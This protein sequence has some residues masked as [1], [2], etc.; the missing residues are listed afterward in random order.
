LSALTAPTSPSI[1]LRTGNNFFFF[2]Q[3]TV[4]LHRSHFGREVASSSLSVDCSS[5]FGHFPG[6]SV[7][8]QPIEAQARQIGILFAEVNAIQARLAAL[9]ESPPHT[10]L[11][12]RPSHQGSSRHCCLQSVGCAN[13]YLT[14]SATPDADAVVADITKGSWTGGALDNLVF[15][16]DT[17]ASNSSGSSS[18]QAVDKA[19]LD[20][21]D[22][23]TAGSLL[24]GYFGHGLGNSVFGQAH[25]DESLQDLFDFDSASSQ[26]SVV[27]NSTTS[28]T[29]VER[30]TSRY[31]DHNT[32]LLHPVTTISHPTNATTVSGPA[33]PNYRC[34]HCN[35]SYA[36][37]SDRDRHARRHNPNARRYPCQFPGCNR[38]GFNAF[39]RKDK[40]KDHRARMGH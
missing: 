7:S 29:V 13:E 10:H 2:S 30:P 8:A 15:N 12:C 14:S 11:P 21:S 16:W 24:D 19:A 23:N 35:K 5:A 26:K 31:N 25:I 38:V 9:E 36:R 3:L 17:K 32:P 18:L 28:P 37:P 22:A 27:G 6:F 39:L 4:C 1:R 20:K 33:Q 40:L 34:S